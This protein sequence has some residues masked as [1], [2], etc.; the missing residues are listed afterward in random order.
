MVLLSRE[1]EKAD[2]S[3]LEIGL[4]VGFLILFWR[5]GAVQTEVTALSKK[6][7]QGDDKQKAN[8]L[9]T[10]DDLDELATK[11][12]LDELAA[13]DDLDELATKDDLG[14]FATKADL[15]TAVSQIVDGVRAMTRSERPRSIDTFPIILPGDYKPSK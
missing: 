8:P 2:M 7:Q 12:D 3:D 10:K 5:I 9:A 13:K 1:R 11:S 6:L 14:D 15:D 4:V